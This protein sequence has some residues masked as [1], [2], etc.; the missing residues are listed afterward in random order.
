[1]SGIN[2][3]DQLAQLIRQQLAARGAQ[4]RSRPAG[5]GGAGAPAAAAPRSARDLVA[6]R[7]AALDPDEPQ[8]ERLAFRIFL[9]SVL[10]DELGSQLMDDPAFYQMVTDIHTRMEGDAELAPALQRAG[11]YL[12]DHKNP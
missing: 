9:E 8:S 2:P 11:R 10:L 3:V 7:V 1:M 12:L 5:T 4:S 6:A